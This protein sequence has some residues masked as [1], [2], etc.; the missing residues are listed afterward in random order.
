M[1]P[2]SYVS[3]EVKSA[4][5]VGIL[6]REVFPPLQTNVILHEYLKTR[7]ERLWV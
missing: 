6:I 2:K 5:D 3:V 7:F 4:K 1:T